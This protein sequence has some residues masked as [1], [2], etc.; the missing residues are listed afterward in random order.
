MAD[1]QFGGSPTKYPAA[2]LAEEKQRWDE[3][4]QSNQ[5]AE[6]GKL[7]A[8]LSSAR[9][10]LAE[11][12]DARHNQGNLVRD[13]VEEVAALQARL[14]SSEAERTDL[15]ILWKVHNEKRLRAY[16]QLTLADALAEAAERLVEDASAHNQGCQSH[17]FDKRRKGADE[18]GQLPCDCAHARNLIATNAALTSYRQAAPT[19][20]ET[21]P[22]SG[23]RLYNLMSR[24]ADSVEGAS[25]AE[26]LAEAATSAPSR[27]EGAKPGMTRD[28]FKDWLYLRCP[29]GEGHGGGCSRGE[30]VGCLYD[31]FASP[32]RTAEPPP[33]A[34]DPH[35]R[36]CDCPSCEEMRA[37]PPAPLGAELRE[38]VKL[39]R[40]SLDGVRGYFE[41][42][43]VA[44]EAAE[45]AV[46]DTDIVEARHGQTYYAQL[47][48]AAATREACA[49]AVRAL[50]VHSQGGE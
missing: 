16:A 37:A 46:R 43:T 19:A 22:D 39:N 10:R 2:A 3:H 30:C 36:G 14:A 38:P 21:V 33:D 23:E 49:E 35:N 24:L 17:R 4:H 7:Q 40:R 1:D 18:D 29:E 41:G 31:L 45:K 26:I 25:D 48:D 42:R 11:L 8:A 34:K 15:E 50:S 47:G 6:I 13:L 9:A 12:D 28:E 32:V 44:L 20:R 27:A 5:N